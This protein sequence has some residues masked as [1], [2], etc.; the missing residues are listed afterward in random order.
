MRLVV[1]IF[2]IVCLNIGFAN[3][4]GTVVG[5]GGF[6]DQ[7]PLPTCPFDLVIQSDGA[8]CDAGGTGYRQVDSAVCSL[9]CRIKVKKGFHCCELFQKSQ[10]SE[11]SDE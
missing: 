6:Q 4:T 10:D 7:D 9:R 3:A 11:S 2:M 8:K 1:S 5:S